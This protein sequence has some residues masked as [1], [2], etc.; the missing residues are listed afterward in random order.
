MPANDDDV[1]W[2]RLVHDD[3]RIYLAATGKGLCYIGS[4]DSPY[5]EMSAWLAARFPGRTL[6]QNDSK[7]EPYTMELIE[8]FQGNRLRF[9]AAVDC[10][11]TPFQ[12]EVWHA[13]ND[14][15]YGR[16]LTYT[17]IAN[18]IGRPS[19]VRAVAA[20]IGANPLLIRIP[21]HRVI[22]KNGA[23]TGYRGGLEMKGRLLALETR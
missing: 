17:E 22:G 10:K 7:L 12:T 23:L 15:P 21:C 6:Q 18:D 19:A 9:E 2:T 4:Q 11:G 13:L 16:T 5:E 14:I 8:Y 20:A 3:W 1:F